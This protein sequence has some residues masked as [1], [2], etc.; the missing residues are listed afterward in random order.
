MKFSQHIIIKTPNAQEKERI[1]KTVKEKIKK[2]TKTDL[3]NFIKL[4]SR[5]SKRQKILGGSHI[6]PRRT[7]MK[8]KS[9][10][11]SKTLNY[12]LW[13]IKGLSK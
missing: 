4:L 12:D 9:T 3:Q 13:K 11:P 10:M 7:K 8:A 2:H 5:D 6:D 1:L